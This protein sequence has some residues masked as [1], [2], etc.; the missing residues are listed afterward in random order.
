MAKNRKWLLH[1]TCRHYRFKSRYDSIQT[2]SLGKLLFHSEK[3]AVHNKTKWSIHITVNV[4]AA[5]TQ[6]HQ[7]K[8]LTKFYNN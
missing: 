8:N 4:N 6:Y 5:V 7:G 2:I 1:V 3:K